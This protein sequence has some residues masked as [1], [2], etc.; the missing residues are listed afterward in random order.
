[1]PW[2]FLTT[3]TFSDLRQNAYGFKPR[4]GDSGWPS[5]LR[6]ELVLSK[7]ESDAVLKYLK[8]IVPKDGYKDFTVTHLGKPRTLPSG[9]C[10]LSTENLVP[11][12]L[13]LR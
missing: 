6:E 13:T 9:K 5:P 1:M 3:E 7:A 12:Q 10:F 2:L 11:F 4:K 8:G